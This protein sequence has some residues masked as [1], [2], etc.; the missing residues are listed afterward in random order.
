MSLRLLVFAALISVSISSAG[1]SKTL[2]Q[3]AREAQKRL[4]DMTERLMRDPY[5]AMG[6]ATLPS[7][8]TVSVRRYLNQILQGIPAEGDVVFPAHMKTTGGRKPLKLEW[9]VD[10]VGSTFLP[11]P[12]VKLA[13]S[14]MVFAGVGSAEN[15]AGLDV[16]GKTV[17]VITDD[18]GRSRGVR[19]SRSDL[20]SQWRTA[21]DRGAAAVLW[22]TSNQ[23]ALQF[24]DSMRATWS[25]VNQSPEFRDP[26]G[27]PLYPLKVA[28]ILSHKGAKKIFANAEVDFDK[29]VA[30]ALRPGF[31]A[32]ALPMKASMTLQVRPADEFDSNSFKVPD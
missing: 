8:K 17:I 26:Q 21:L 27:H 25:G 16:A 32:F 9:S 24:W 30:A 7:G 11:G 10:V 3:E 15:Y 22:V 31:R 12:E 29:S 19:T 1:S 18:G 23:P 20:A 2:E 14:E 4:D 13:D 5:E 28:G 6:N